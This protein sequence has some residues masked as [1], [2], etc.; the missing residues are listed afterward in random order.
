METRTY[1]YRV[2]V[3]RMPKILGVVGVGLIVG[4]GALMLVSGSWSIAPAIGFVA[5]EYLFLVW[6]LRRIAT[7]EITLGASGIEFENHARKVQIPYDAIEAIDSGSLPYLGGW[8]K[9]RGGGNTV[10]ATVTLEGI[11]DF[12]QRLKRQVDLHNPDAVYN[13][14][15]LFGFFK[16]ASYCEQSWARLTGLG[17]GATFV[18]LAVIFAP[19]LA[20]EFAGAAAVIPVVAGVFAWLGAEAVFARRVA[21]EADEVHFSVPRRDSR[22]ERRTYF[23]ATVAWLVM[24]VPAVGFL[25]L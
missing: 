18:W 11:T 5:L 2:H 25:L 4:L 19:I 20:L 14:G 24:V 9:V 7:T 23:G 16:T 22:Y 1:R 15:S 3:K 6:L 13:R 21:R 12:V 8:V 10:R 17:K